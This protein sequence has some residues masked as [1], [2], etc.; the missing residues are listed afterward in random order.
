M[1]GNILSNCPF[2]SAKQA[3]KMHT[4]EP[5]LNDCSS[6]QV[7][8]LLFTVVRR[9]SYL[10]MSSVFGWKRYQR[11]VARYT[12][13]C[14]GIT[15]EFSAVDNTFLPC[16]DRLRVRSPEPSQIRFNQRFQHST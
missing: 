7:S 2:I 9:P 5:L 8:K 11:Q 13:R 10:L 3:S 15:Q 4:P 12:S 14:P 1:A 6:I 16:Q